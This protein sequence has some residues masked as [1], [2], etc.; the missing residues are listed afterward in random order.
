MRISSRSPH[1]VLYL[2]A[3]QHLTDAL[4]YRINRRHQGVQP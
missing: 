4:T 3:I 2:T 1:L